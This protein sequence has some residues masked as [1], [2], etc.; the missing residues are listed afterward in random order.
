MVKVTKMARYPLRL[1][2]T[3]YDRV[4]ALAEK[5]KRSINQQLVY[6]VAAQLGPPEETKSE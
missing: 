4:K 6:M 1:P 3:L 2:E 5:E